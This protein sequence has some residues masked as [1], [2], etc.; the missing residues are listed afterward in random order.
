MAILDPSAFLVA[1]IMLAINSYPFL[2]GSLIYDIAQDLEIA[3][4]VGYTAVTSY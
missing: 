2:G 4:V 3:A 1:L